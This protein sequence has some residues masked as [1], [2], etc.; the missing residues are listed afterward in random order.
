MD[1]KKTTFQKSEEDVTKATKA[2]KDQV[3][4]K[5]NIR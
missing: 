2:E 3:L 5:L 1:Q 4:G